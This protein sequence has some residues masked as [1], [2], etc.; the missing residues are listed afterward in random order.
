MP[1][2]GNVGNTMKQTRD[3]EIVMVTSRASGGKSS[4]VSRLRRAFLLHVHPDRFRNHNETVRKQQATLVQALSDRMAEHDFLTYSASSSSKSG[5]SISIHNHPRKKLTSDSYPF[6]VE[7]KDGTISKLSI[8]LDST[9]PHQILSQMAKS[10]NFPQPPPSPIASP[11]SESIPFDLMRFNQSATD[12]DGRSAGGGFGWRCHEHKSPSSI[13]RDLL[14]FLKHTDFDHIRQRKLSRIHATAAALVARRAFAFS[15][16]DGT[17]LG[18]SSSSLAI[19]LSRLTSL[20]EEHSAKLLVRSFYPF[21]LLLSSDEF[22]QRIDTFSG[23]LRLNPA[24]TSLQWL[25]TLA[26]VTDDSVLR[27]KGNRSELERNVLEV[28][29][30]LGIRPIKGHSCEPEEYHICLGRLASEIRRDNRNSPMGKSELTPS[31]GNA[32]LVIES[33]LDCRRGELRT[34]GNFV[35][36]AGTDL[37]GIRKTIGEY[38]SRSIEYARIDEEKRTACLILA[39]RIMREFGVLKV[40]R[41]GHG[42]TSDDMLQ[43]MYSLLGKD[44]TERDELRGYLT[45]QSIGIARR[46]HLCHLGDDGSIVIPTNCS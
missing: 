34:D 24:A 25:G 20:H 3:E 13:N 30:A 45:G 1:S 22:H 21:R 12:R 17:G 2:S 4:Y 28:E 9:D 31:N 18:W 41:I 42:V 5:A 37:R 44:V 7:G 29:D 8:Q 35:V 46:G 10:I 26:L 15:A 6:W 36:G 23:I 16:I 33:A 27:L 38:A 32:A 14:H 19:C 39:E 11:L 40:N 43:C